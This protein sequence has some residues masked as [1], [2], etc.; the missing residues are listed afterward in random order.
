LKAHGWDIFL[1][2][3]EGYNLAVAHAFTQTF[4]GFR[5]K[6]GDVQLEVTE[7]FVAW[8]TRLPQEVEK[9]F[10]LSKL[11]DVPLMQSPLLS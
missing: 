4:D 2:K 8:E 9:W 1:R 3:F 11:E 6:V 7:D 10:K 5:A